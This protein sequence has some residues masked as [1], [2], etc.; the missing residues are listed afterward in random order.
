MDCLLTIKGDN[1]GKYGRFK[2]DTTRTIRDW[3]IDNAVVYPKV[4][5]HVAECPKCD[6]IEIFT[7]Y[8]ERR[9]GKYAPHKFAYMTGTL[10]KLSHKYEKLCAK[11]GTP[12]P[13]EILHEVRLH[14]N[15]AE[16]LLHYENEF[17][18][19][20]IFKILKDFQKR[21][22][23]YNPKNLASKSI[24]YRQI[25]DVMES[26]EEC[27]DEKELENLLKVA[28]VLLT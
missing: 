6:P 9:R 25:L 14:C 2:K 7:K 16:I 19:T 1:R 12:L 10:V 28:D 27:P 8:V 24:K 11:R 22:E 23:S 3:I 15:N 26:I 18:C 5:A 13:K 20:E 17:S 4:L 21:G